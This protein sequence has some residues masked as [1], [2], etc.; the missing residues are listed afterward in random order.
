MMAANVLLLLLTLHENSMQLAY[1]FSSIDVV[2]KLLYS[3]MQ[4]AC[5]FCC[6]WPLM[7]STFNCYT[8]VL[9]L[10]LVIQDK[11]MQ[12]H[13]AILLQAGCPPC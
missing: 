6:C 11:S 4:L 7:L 1:S 3:S 10:L 2:E 5:V 12:W 13:T 8:A 9:L